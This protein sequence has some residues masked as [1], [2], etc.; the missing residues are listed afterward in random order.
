MKIKNWTVCIQD[1]GKWWDVVEKA[2]TFNICKEEEE[3]ITKRPG[4]AYS[5]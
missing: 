2:K 4:V 3:K 1:R 5:G